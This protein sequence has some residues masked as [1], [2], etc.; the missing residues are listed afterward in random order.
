MYYLDKTFCSFYK[1]CKKGKECDR[2]LTPE[3]V[4][5]ANRWMEDAPIC[6]FVDKPKCFKEND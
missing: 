4:G 5:K 3:I 2:A 6:K 1:E